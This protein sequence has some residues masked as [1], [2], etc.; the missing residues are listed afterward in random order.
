M[1]VM[2][3]TAC[4]LQV[5]QGLVTLLLGCQLTNCYRYTRGHLHYHHGTNSLSVT[6][7]PEVGYT[8][9]MVQPACLLQV[10]QR[11]VT[12][13]SW[14]HQPVC[15]RCTRGWLHYHHGTTSLSVTGVP[16]VGYTTIMVPTAC[17]LQVHLGLVTLPS[18]YQQPVCYRY[19]WGWLHY[20]HGTNS[21]LQVYQ[22]LVTLPSWYQQPVCYRYTRGWLHYH[23]GTNGLVTGIPDGYIAIMV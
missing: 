16:E 17:L 15:Y 5:Y 13:P 11:L 7:V 23:H 8:T 3:P 2:V 20:H 22:R 4:L 10:Y 21:L 9:I 14:Y 1:S 12:L 18:W 19:T 6:G